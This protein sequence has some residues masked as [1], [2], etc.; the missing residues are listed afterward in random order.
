M[1][2]LVQD[3]GIVRSHAPEVYRPERSRVVYLTFEGLSD[4]R[5]SSDRHTRVRVT[6]P[7][8][9]ATRLRELLAE[10]ADQGTPDIVI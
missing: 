5:T 7:V 9:E 4:L 3:I 2:C 10:P 8:A 6:L 1:L